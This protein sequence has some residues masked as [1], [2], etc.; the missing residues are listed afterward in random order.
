MINFMINDTSTQAANP[1]VSGWW[2]ILAVVFVALS[3]TA[4]GWLNYCVYAS[5]ERGQFGDTFGAVNALFSGLAFAT[6]IYTMLLQRKELKLTLSEM[7]DQQQQM[8]IQNATLKKQQFEGTFFQ[9]LAL[10]G[11]VVENMRTESAMRTGVVL[12]AIGRTRI[13]L[14]ERELRSEY[15][16]L[17][18][19]REAGMPDDV[20]IEKAY[21]A[22]YPRAEADLGHYFRT[23]YNIVKFVDRSDLTDEGKRFYMNL[24]RAQLSSQEQVLLFYNC[25]TPR[26]SEKF[27]PLIEKHTLF[28][29]LDSKQLFGPHVHFYATS[30]FVR[31]SA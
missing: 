30:A 13:G 7:S 3:W 23:V 16:R 25:L 12:T 2:W 15:V 8:K 21:D 6:L 10:Y 18:D 4:S 17:I 28:K 11:S 29:S 9:L 14:F 5:G 22:F 19:S 31:P 26:G 27:K 24:I 1:A 20:A